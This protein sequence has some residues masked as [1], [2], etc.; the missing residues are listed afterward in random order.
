MTH[1]ALARSLSPL[2]ALFA[3]LALVAAAILTGLLTTSVSDHAGSRWNSS[4]SNVAGSRWNSHTTTL[5][6]S[7]WNALGTTAGSRWN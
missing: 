1:T 7:R 6:G 2:A 3:V 5:A 4:N